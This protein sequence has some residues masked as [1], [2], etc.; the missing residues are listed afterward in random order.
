M[1]KLIPLVVL[2]LN[3]QVGV[4][5]T[6]AHQRCAAMGKGMNLSNWLEAAWQT[7]WPTANGYSKQSLI[8]MQEAGIQSLRLP[9]QFFQVIDT[10]P[11]YT[12]NLGHPLFER[13]DS[14]IAWA[15]ELGM[16]VIID[17]HHGW[18]LTNAHWRNKLGAFTHL[19]AVLAQKYSYL[20]PNRY[21]FELLNEP[22]LFFEGDSLA[23]MFGDAID[24]IRQH[25]TDHTIIVSPHFG[26]S[27]LM[28][29]QMPIYADT[30]LIY[31]WHTY[32][33]L[34]FT[35]QGLTWNTPYF[36][37]G[38]P[39]PNADTTVLETWMYNGWQNVA[40]WIA[41]N[42]LPIMLG[43]FGVSN[44]ADPTSTCNWMTFVGLK[45]REHNI[46]WFYWDWQWDFSL[47]NSN[48]IGPDSIVPCLR[49]AL[50][51]YGDNTLGINNQP[52][53]D[54]AKLTVYP[55][56]AVPFSEVSLSGILASDEVTVR[57]LHGQTVSMHRGAKFTSPQYP[58]IYLIDVKTKSNYLHTTL[59]VQ[60]N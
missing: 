35:H 59:V 54:L 37:S 52:K 24:S 46:P 57:N 32:D 48:T 17:N 56:P 30:N 50:G 21:T 5:Q 10:L 31:T 43:E 16:N 51:L 41:Q 11:P 55:N 23:V 4:G 1:L 26:G 40:N 38:N 22:T 33:P 3:L 34:D 15:N 39:F 20:D 19:W 53:K 58:G 2:T 13:V 29:P 47:F 6:V 18:D 49:T 8:L 44:F 25:T 9:V 36:P 27:A 42:N 60:C 45:L 12:V 7:N 28:L 14:V